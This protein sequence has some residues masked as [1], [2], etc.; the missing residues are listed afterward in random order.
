VVRWFARWLVLIGCASC[1][2]GGSGDAAGTGPGT[3]AVAGVTVSA[4]STSIPAGQSVQLS[5]AITDAAGSLL[6]NRTIN[7]TSSAPTVAS[8]SAAGLVTGVAPGTA[9]IS[10][11]CEGKTGS[12][13]ITVTTVSIASVVLSPP[14]G[15]V[16]AGGTLQ[17]QVGVFDATGAPV[18]GQ[19]VVWT[20]SDPSRATVS[21][22]GLVSAVG[23]AA[24]PQITAESPGAITSGASLT[25][26]G[27]N[28]ST[29]AGSVSVL[30]AGVP[31]LVTS[32]T[33]TR[34]VAAIPPTFPCLSSG[35]TTLSVANALGTVTIT[36]A[37]AGKS[38][39]ATVSIG[40]PAATWPVTL[41]LAGQLSLAPGQA[42]FIGDGTQVGCNELTGSAGR[43]LIS[44]Y[45]VSSLPLS[46]S[47]FELRGAAA[48]SAG[49]IAASVRAPGAAYSPAPRVPARQAPPAALAF[50][51]GARLHDADGHAERLARQSA[52]MRPF[53][54]R[55]KMPGARR[56]G[57]S[58]A[59]TQAATVIPLTVGQ[60]TVIKVDTAG[61]CDST[62]A[63]VV[64]RVV[65]VGAR[66]IVLEDTRAPLAT[67]MDSDYIKL[68]KAFDVTMFPILTQYF[69]NPFAYDSALQKLGKITM[70]FTPVVNNAASNLLGF[71]S[72]CDMYPASSDA[73]LPASNNTELFYGRVPTAA[74]GNISDVN[75][76]PGWNSVIG[77]TLIHEAKHITTLAERF[78]DPVGSEPTDELWFEE[79]TAQ[80]APEFYARTVYGASLTWKN[81]AVYANTVR[82]DF[83]APN[84]QYLM[85][86]DFLFL[87]GYLAASEASSFMS[88]PAV[89]P[90]VHGSAWLFARWLLD[91]YSTQE[92]DLLKPL[93]KDATMVGI[94]NITNKTG[95][96]WEELDGY[97]TLALGADDYPGF[98]PPANARYMV[99]SWNLRSVYAGLNGDD[100]TDFVAWPLGT[101]PVSFGSWTTRV[102][103]LLGGSGAIFDLSGT[104][105]ARQLLDLHS[106][107]G[108]PL[109]PGHTLRMAIVRIQ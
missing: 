109:D 33:A 63:K 17:L 20:S 67:K 94:Q 21:A 1:G 37:V 70:L 52:I 88:P 19:A 47:A 32:A 108:A 107:S 59:A 104:Q 6:T 68:A 3:A 58:L 12:L 99:P 95:R 69:G 49:S 25:I 56:S 98:T 78:A 61:L 62:Y 40:S 81:D 101:H 39:S 36:A 74:T 73:G 54:T 5:A 103:T 86:D 57:V 97:F 79:G 27:S 72:Q 84:A 38:A 82:N 66:S 16:A 48:S 80:L 105:T 55:M 46:A 43:Y 51:R 28:F 4:S 22:N 93:I 7:W 9:T 24:A 64:A 76:R 92:S 11:I 31:V 87:Y 13:A 18:T 85:G 75:S 26:T 53:L 14:A 8:V 83:F 71:V 106:L 30:V 29:A 41:Q 34:L 90:N 45:N 10:A 65:Y 50:A 35:N 102:T 44:V 42:L 15:L 100:P 91:Q 23:T 2:G 60:S 77:G 96:T 89:D